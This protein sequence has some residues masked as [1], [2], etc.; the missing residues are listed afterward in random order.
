ML[1][2]NTCTCTYGMYYNGSVIHVHVHVHMYYNGTVCNTC[3]YGTVIHTTILEQ[4]GYTYPMYYMYMFIYGSTF[5]EIYH[6]TS[7]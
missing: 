6:F 5:V 3:T 4:Y 7:K 2:C 1:Y